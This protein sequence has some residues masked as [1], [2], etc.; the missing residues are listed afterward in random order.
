MKK[1]V[2]F[3]FL[4]TAGLTL[5]A[6]QVGK[7]ALGRFSGADASYDYESA[8]VKKEQAALKLQ[9]GQENRGKNI[10]G[11]P[12]GC[13]YASIYEPLP[14]SYLA[15]GRIDFMGSSWTFQYIDPK[16]GGPFVTADIAENVGTI[17]Q[18]PEKNTVPS[19]VRTPQDRFIVAQ[20]FDRSYLG[21][22]PIVTCL[23]QAFKGNLVPGRKINFGDDYFNAY[24]RYSTDSWDNY[25][26]EKYGR[27]QNT[28]YP[29]QEPDTFTV[30]LPQGNQDKI[31]ITLPDNYER[32]HGKVNIIIREKNQEP[33]NKIIIEVPDNFSQTKEGRIRVL[34]PYDFST[35]YGKIHMRL[36]EPEKNIKGKISIT[37]PK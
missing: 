11:F 37:L 1:Y 18:D 29:G 12:E 32:N 36:P 19:L 25:R 34:L 22:N 33:K 35:R 4:S 5:S 31:I 14:D 13:A 27:W 17:G 28:W 21:L 23:S 10:L 2:F 30:R 3:I 7:A 15:F 9:A 26:R 24:R 6:R 20:I 8:K 16:A